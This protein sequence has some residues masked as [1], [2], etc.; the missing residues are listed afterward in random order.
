MYIYTCIQHM[1]HVNNWIHFRAKAVHTANHIVWALAFLHKSFVVSS[2]LI[3][4]I[5]LIWHWLLKCLSSKSTQAWN[6]AKP[7]N[8]HT[9]SVFEHFKQKKTTSLDHVPRVV[10]IRTCSLKI[11]IVKFSPAT[12]TTLSFASCRLPVPV[13]Q[14]TS[15]S[16]LRRRHEAVDWKVQ[17]HRVVDTWRMR[18]NVRPSTHGEMYS[19]G[20]GW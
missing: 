13:S 1:M 4:L 17:N 2:L 9:S 19:L 18:R 14:G 6:R 15:T 16:P 5:S 10:V 11:H 12:C 7:R 3:D 20:G 8:T